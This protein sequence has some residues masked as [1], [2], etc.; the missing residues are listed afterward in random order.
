MAKVRRIPEYNGSNLREIIRVI[1]ENMQEFQK[2]ITF[3]NIRTSSPMFLG[4]MTQDEIDNLND[5]QNGWVVYNETDGITQFYEGSS[6]K[7]RN[8][9]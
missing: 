9:A 3:E 5:P 7:D 2:N 8:S 1:N 6:W 4:S